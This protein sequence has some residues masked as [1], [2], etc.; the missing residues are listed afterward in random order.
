[1]STAGSRSGAMD[2]FD[3]ARSLAA[4]TLVASGVAAII[5]S[6]LSWVTIEPPPGI[7]PNTDFGDAAIERVRVTEPF[8]GVEAGDGRWV[9][10]AGGIMVVAAILLVW[11]RRGL[12]AWISLLASVFIGA[13]AFADYRGIGD[14]SSA[15]S[16][17]MDI[18]GQA[19]PAIGITLVATAAVVGLL[20][21]AAG[22]AAT[23]YRRE[24]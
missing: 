11:R 9:V 18:V 4:A 3:K 7:D 21:S 20:A 14:L 1:M 12:Y 5:G 24:T 15:L 19:R 17:R 13:I 6:L 22:I 16:R 8:T 10:A 2:F 23:P